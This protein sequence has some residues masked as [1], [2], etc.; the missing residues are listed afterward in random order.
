MCYDISFSTSIETIADFFPEVTAEVQMDF[1]FA[2]MTH[3][4]GNFVFP[5][6]PILYRSNEDKQIHLQVMEWGVIPYYAN[7]DLEKLQKQ[8]PDDQKKAFT[9]FE[10]KLKTIRNGM[11][12]ARSERVLDDPGSY[13][14]KIKNRR[15]L[16]PVDGIYEHREVAGRKNKIPY[17]VWLKDQP[18]FFLPG[19]RSVV[20]LPDKDTGEMVKRPTFTLITRGANALMKNIHNHGENKHRMPLFLPFELAK[21]WLDDELPEAEYRKVLGFEM[22]SE[23]LEFRT[24]YTIRGPKGRPDG[25]PKNQP[26]AWEG[27]TDDVRVV[28]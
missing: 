27:Y 3:V 19:L 7:R 8:F 11:L 28:V 23:N 1:D 14:Y 18:K 12:N 5:P 24:V 26:F 16:I 17:L 15:C 9:E 22:P 4:M 25:L 20:E 10:K 21:R 13:W 6:Y 2:D